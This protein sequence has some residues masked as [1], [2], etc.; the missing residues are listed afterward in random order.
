MPNANIAWF[1]V[2]PKGL[3]VVRQDGRARLPNDA[4]LALLGVDASANQKLGELGGQQAL[5]VEVPRGFAP[6]EPFAVMGL[7]ELFGHLGEQGFA[8]AARASQVIEWAS[9]HKFCGRCA[10]PTVQVEHERCMKC[11]KCTLTAYPRISPAIIVLVRRGEEALLARN[12]RFP[13][14]FFSTLAGFSE[15]GE[16]L[17]ETLVREVREEVSIDVT[18]PRYFGSQPWPFPHSLMIGYTADYAGGEIKVD[19]KEI[20]EA[21]WFQADAL[22]SIPPKL[23]IARRLIDQ[24]LADVAKS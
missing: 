12:A 5:A 17:E 19:G 11:P 6:Q 16:T 8:F 13:G 4:E 23:S 1:L 7:R 24:W 14:A 9:T 15:I 20:A 10:T 3:V 18:N 22:P 21:R 2:H